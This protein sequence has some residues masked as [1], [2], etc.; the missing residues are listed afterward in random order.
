MQWSSMIQYQN[1]VK[2]KRRV[3]L[4]KKSKK[5]CS[6]THY[7]NRELNIHKFHV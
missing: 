4:M 5:I 1:I 3:K 6:D 2:E 7:V